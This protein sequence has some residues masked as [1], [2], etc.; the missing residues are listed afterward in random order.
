ME[1]LFQISAVG[2]TEKIRRIIPMAF[3]DDKAATP[4]FTFTRDM[5]TKSLPS[6]ESEFKT[7]DITMGDFLSRQLTRRFQTL[8]AEDERIAN[9]FSSVKLVVRF[10]PKP[11]PQFLFNAVAPLRGEMAVAYTP[12][13]G[14]H[15]D[16]IYF[17]E[18]IAR[19]FVE[20]L[21]SYSFQD[22]KCLKFQLTQ[23][24]QLLTWSATREELE[25]FRRHK[26]TL[27]EILVPSALNNP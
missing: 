18:R 21:R 4:D 17:W 25:L 9:T 27:R 1:Y 5:V 10:D 22:Y 8:A 2:E 6:W 19:E 14:I 13:Q 26:K 11:E 16:V 3:L 20:V 15:E 7:P 24:G 12:E 23:G